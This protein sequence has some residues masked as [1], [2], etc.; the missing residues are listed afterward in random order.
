MTIIQQSEKWSK[1]G[2]EKAALMRAAA[3]NL[4]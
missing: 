2:K 4:P 3:V 1:T